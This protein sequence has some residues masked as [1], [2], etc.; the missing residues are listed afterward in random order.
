MLREHRGFFLGIT[1]CGLALRLFFL[2]YFPAVSDD[3]HVYLDLANNWQQHGV[4][5]LTE[6]GA[7]VPADTRLPGYPAFLAALSWIFGAGKIRTIL[8]IQILIDLAGCLLIADLA[9]RTLSPRAGR[10]AFLLAALCPFLASYAAAVLTE[11]L[12]L[13]FTVLAMECTVAALDRTAN[14]VRRRVWLLWAGTGASVAACILL[15]PDGGILLPVIGVAML[16][17]LWRERAS[18]KIVFSILTG[19]CFV[20]VIALAPLVPWTMRNWKTLHQFQPL[21]PRYATESEEV[22]PIGFNRWV[23]TWMADYVSVEEIYWNMPGGKID[24][25]KLPRRALDSAPDATLTLIADYNAAPQ[26]T[27][28]L[29]WR[30]DQVAWERIR[31]HPFRYYVLLRVL[32]V[33][34]MWLRPRTELLP[35]DPRWWEFNDAVM[36]S[37]ASVGFGLI[38]L[39]YVAAAIGGALWRRGAFR[40]FWLLVGFVVLRTA[41][42]LTI[43][44][45]EPRYTLECYPVVI[46]LAAALLAGRHTGNVCETAIS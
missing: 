25:S 17:I 30:F 27:A 10:V 28:Q 29:D 22:T 6:D 35:A 1:L 20:A 3:S 34:D 32:R 14:H 18:K 12:E 46:V 5:G 2:F 23:A 39:F 37:V 43:E 9:R 7:V 24:A 42:L 33:A 44:N 21:A 40:Y 8:L 41:F 11:T 26:L 4:Y 16:F 13:F 38:N 15:R 19:G 45:P 36:G 31:A